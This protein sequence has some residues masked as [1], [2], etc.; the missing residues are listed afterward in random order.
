MTFR[1]FLDTCTLVPINSAD[2]LLRCAEKGM[3]Q[4][5]WS[6][7]VLKELSDVLA[8]PKIEVPFEKIQHRIECMRQAFPDSEVVGW[9]PLESAFSN[10]P[11]VKDHH[12]AAAAKLS[13]ADVIVTRNLKHFPNE[14]LKVHNN[15]YSQPPDEFMLDLWDLKPSYPLLIFNI[16]KNISECRKIDWRDFILQLPHSGMSK[17]STCVREWHYDFDDD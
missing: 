16:I 9:Q 11:D 2:L 17:F 14:K 12:V 4:V 3:F 10:L 13:K 5:R 7:K 1:A 15:I 6:D 8:R